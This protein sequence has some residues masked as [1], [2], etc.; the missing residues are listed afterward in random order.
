MAETKDTRS[1][2]DS[3]ETQAA[4]KMADH[5]MQA[6]EHMQWPDAPEQ[7]PDTAA[8][9]ERALRAAERAQQ[10]ADRAA[11]TVEQRNRSAS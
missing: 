7:E 6:P 5:G 4:R 2:V 1:D 3:L 10:A 9:V 11:E 8:N